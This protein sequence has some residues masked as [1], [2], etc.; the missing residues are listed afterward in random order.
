[1]QFHNYGEAQPRLTSGRRSRHERLLRQ[2]C[3]GPPRYAENV[4]QRNSLV[5]DFIASPKLPLRF[6][7]AAGTFEID[8]EGTGGNI[9][10]ATRH[11]RDVLG[12]K[13]YDVHYQQFVGGHDG[14][15]WRGLLADGLMVLFGPR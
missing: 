10:E 4:A 12:A 8:R 1:M 7:L 5:K 11:L 14:V 6:Y 15:S 13:G 9:L 2:S 3:G